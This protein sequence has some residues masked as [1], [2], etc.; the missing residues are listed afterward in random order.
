[1][2]MREFEKLN[3]KASLLG[4]GGM[5]FPVKDGKIDRE[6]AQR[7]IDLAYEN[8]VNYYDTA[9]LYHGGESETFLGEALSKFPRESIYIADKMPPGELHSKED[10]EKMFEGQLKKLQTDYFD[11]YLIH[12][13]GRNSIPKIKEYD[14][15]NFLKKK[16][17]E[18]KIKYLGFSLHDTPEALSELLLLH[19]WDFVQLQLNYVDWEVIRARENYELLVRK[20]IP[21][22]VM[23]PVRGGTLHNF[24]GKTREIFIK[25][26]PN[27]TLAS[28]A[29]RWVASLPNVKVIL[30]GMSTL[31]QVKDNLQTCSEFKPL[32]NEE[33][34]VIGEALDIINEAPTV[35]CTA[36]KYCMPCPVGVNIPENFIYFNEYIKYENIGTLKWRCNAQ[37]KKEEKSSECISC[38]LCLEKCPQHIDIPTELEKIT[39]LLNTETNNKWS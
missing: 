24:S 21:C 32:T 35:P 22:I 18:G 15:I 7:M 19:D 23:E 11:F 2:Q 13:I 36:C 6:L 33:F 27:A 14:M 1:M 31:E 26:N 8:G 9:V 20:N 28:W 39:K 38:G 10:T 5:R 16:R 17:A 29:I 25:A 12:G 3:V 30:S 34:A 37:L 4:F